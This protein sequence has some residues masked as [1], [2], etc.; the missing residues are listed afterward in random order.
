VTAGRWT[1][2]ASLLAAVVLSYL[3]TSQS[4][5]TT[6]DFLNAYTARISSLDWDYLSQGVYQHFAPGHRLVDW[7][8]WR[9][10]TFNW[11]VAMAFLYAAL[12]LAG[13]LLVAILDRLSGRRWWHVLVGCW[14]VVSF[15]WVRSIEWWANGLHTVPGALGGLATIYCSIRAFEGKPSWRWPILAGLALAFGL[16]FYEKPLLAVLYAPLL[17]LVVFTPRLNARGVFEAARAEWRLWTMLAAVA[18][19][20]YVYW[21]AQDY[22]GEY[23]RPSLSLLEEY[24]RILWLRGFVPALFG[25]R[26]Q[27]DASSGEDVAIV[28]GQVALWAFVGWTL[29]R[30]RQAW[31]AWAFFAIAFVLNALLLGIS[32]IVQFGTSVA[33]DARYSTE[34][35]PI[36]A[37]AAALATSFDWPREA[38]R[39]NREA[40]TRRPPPVATGVAV[41]VA[42][43]LFLLL[44]GL[45]SNGVADEWPAYKAERYYDGLRASVANYE[46]RMSHRPSV[47]DEPVI[48]EVVPNF[49]SPLNRAKYVLPTLRVDAEYGTPAGELHGIG[50]DGSLVP[51]RFMGAGRPAVGL[52]GNRLVRA[53]GNHSRCITGPESLEWRLTQPAMAP[54]TDLRLRGAANKRSAIPVF[55]DETGQG[56]PPYDSGVVPTRAASFSS[57]LATTRESI[58]ALRF[59]IPASVRLCVRF[60]EIGDWRPRP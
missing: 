33:L 9:E 57:G 51:L 8:L 40:R 49:L 32:R 31:R 4:W 16:A 59:D 56:F 24:G 28:A 2:A 29:W 19:P 37:I 36:F 23:A 52:R 60:V 58:R 39:G 6:D 1:T 12:G 14:F 55:V 26:V 46:A 45:S 53:A 21:S 38:H 42:S 25:V 47:L 17:R 34:Y 54:E 43:G 10:A 30:R 48:E 11:T 5:F 35:L 7:V 22:A 44:N 20:W 41:A 15:V 3:W 13:A 50:A 18:M 27:V